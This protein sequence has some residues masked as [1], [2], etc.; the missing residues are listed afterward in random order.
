MTY[1]LDLFT[2]TTW[3]EFQTAGAKTTGFREHNWSRSKSIRPGDIFLC[4]LVGVKRW[5]GLLEITSERYRDESRIFEEEVFPVRFSVKP[6][7][8][9][10]PEHGVPMEALAGKLTF[11]PPEATARNWSG[12]V[13]G[14]PNKYKPED[15]EV[16]AEAIRQA[17]A[18]P[19]SRPVN[20]RQGTTC[21]S[22]QT[23]GRH[24]RG[25]GRDG[26][27][28]TGQRGGRAGRRRA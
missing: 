26:G 15:G 3:K 10:P 23:Q 11:Y 18:S 20:S 21:K 14:S 25:R 6:L 9:L 22:L 5:V 28:H 8:L 27:E 12:Y 7:V 2:G 13:R 16:I 19:V 17:A 24:R 1:W 4:Y